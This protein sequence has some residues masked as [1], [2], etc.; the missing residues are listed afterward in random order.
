[1]P[2]GELTAPLPS[3]DTI[4]VLPERQP[5]QLPA[6]SD[7]EPAGD[8]PEMPEEDTEPVLLIGKARQA[9]ARAG[10]TRVARALQRARGEVASRMEARVEGYFDDLARAVAERAERVGKAQT[11]ALPN[12]EQLLLNSDEAGLLGIFRV[13]TFEILRASWEVWNQA[14]DVELAF[15]ESDPAVVAALAQSGTRITG[16][17]E[18]TRTAVR[19]L[20][21]YGASEGWTI[22][23]LVRGDGDQPGLRDMVAESYKGRARAISRT[24]VGTAQQ[25]A[26]VARYQAAGVRRVTV[27]DGGGDD[28]DDICNQLNGTTQTLA[29]AEANP[30]Q[31]PNCVRSFA[32]AFDD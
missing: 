7:R 28:S 9:K 4:T 17:V 24:E 8:A 10:A 22:D 27:L 1:V 2:Y 5:A 3:G 31:H 19:E 13:F 11:K 30:L 15:D 16:I 23:Q 29:W 25:V 20:L 21:E 26:S 12:V 32:P 14:L 18:T 6:P